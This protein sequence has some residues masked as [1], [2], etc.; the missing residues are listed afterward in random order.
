MED[1]LIIWVSA[2][3]VAGLIACGITVYAL[4]KAP[5]G[6]EDAKGFHQHKK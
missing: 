3:V 5:D 6:S 4:R 2:L 1:C